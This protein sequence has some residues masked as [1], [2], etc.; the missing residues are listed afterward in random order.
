MQ[1]SQFLPKSILLVVRRGG[2]SQAGLLKLVK[3]IGQAGSSLAGQSKKT[4]ANDGLRLAQP[5]T[6]SRDLHAS[7][8][9]EFDTLLESSHPPH[10]LR[11]PHATRS[12]R[13]SSRGLVFRRQIR[14][15]LRCCSI[16]ASPAPPTRMPVSQS[17]LSA[18]QN[19]RFDEWSSQSHTQA[20]ILLV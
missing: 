8:S 6:T 13:R 4:R 19:P 16:R 5:P 15:Y 11:T 12:P 2:Y 10:T 3:V 9:P 7:R 18:H 20:R 1:H 17:M 14:N